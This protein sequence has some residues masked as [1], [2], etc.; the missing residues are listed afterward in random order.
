MKSDN[1]EQNLEQLADAVGTRNSFVDDVMIRIKNSSVQL[2]K[3]SKQNIVL[4]RILMKNTLKY[5]AAAVI[6]IAAVLSLTLIDTIPT[7]YALEQTIEALNA[8]RSIH[9]RMYYPGYEEPVL[10]WIRF[11]ENGQLEALRVSQS[12]LAPGDPHDG[13]KE[14]TWKDNVAHLWLKEKKTLFR[15][16]DRTEAAKVANLFQELN[17]KLLV[18]KLEQMQKEGTAQVEI[19][20]P[21]AIDQPITITA[22]LTEEHPLLGHQVV[23]L[24][25]QATKLVI[26][27]ETLKGDGV[28]DPKTENFGMNDFSQLEFYDYN[29]SFEEDIFNLEVPEDTVILD[30]IEKVI[31]LEQGQMSDKEVVVEVVNR[32][33]NNILRQDF[34]AAGLLY[35]GLPGNLIQE[36]YGPNSEGKIVRILSIGQPRRHP[37]PDYE[38]GLLVPCSIEV[39]K[40][41]NVETI[42]IKYLVNEVHGQTNRWSICGEF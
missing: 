29:Q 13:P 6:L 38:R 26:S 24:V 39:E 2:S 37:N 20:Q 16:Y 34:E 7:A 32:F 28:F 40:N 25:D 21:D 35:Q 31:G 14:V 33:L 23:A 3:K 9:V 8:M 4:R 19:E 5:T 10:V 11:H 17:P 12:K 27:L 30:H 1:I 42:D 36:H 41:G 18:Q 15:I 22:T